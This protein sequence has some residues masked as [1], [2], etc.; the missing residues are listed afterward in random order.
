MKSLSRNIK[1][2]VLHILDTYPVVIGALLIYGYYLAVSVDFFTNYGE[3]RGLLSMFLQF[4]SV[5]LIWGVVFALIQLQKFHKEKKQE[6]EWHRGLYSAF[7]RQRLALSSLDQICDLMNDRI[8]NPLSV[9]SLST[10]SLRRQMQEDH[11]LSREVEQLEGSIR[12]IQEVMIGLESYYAKK[13]VKLSRDIMADAAPNERE[14][15][16]AAV[17]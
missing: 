13:I 14:Q 17:P 8:N 1:K 4:D 5:I 6:E 3:K 7:E 11:S 2:S 16:I 9:I 15:H 12:R 10:S